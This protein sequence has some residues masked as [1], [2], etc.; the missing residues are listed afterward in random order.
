MRQNFIRLSDEDVP[1]DDLNEWSETIMELA[2]WV[3]DMSL[4]LENERGGG[5]IGEN[6]KWLIGNAVTKYHESMDRLRK[7]EE[8]MEW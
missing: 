6:E 8:Q 3:A 7:I 2:G 1:P 5:R 4:L